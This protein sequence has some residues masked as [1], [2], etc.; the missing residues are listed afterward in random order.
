MTMLLLLLLLYYSGE[1]STDLRDV[2]QVPRPGDLD[3]RRW[4]PSSSSWRESWIVRVNG[5]AAKLGGGGSYHH[6]ERLRLSWDSLKSWNE[7]FSMVMA[8]YH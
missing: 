4:D 2:L 6:H 5:V 8:F 1:H 7:R 3:E